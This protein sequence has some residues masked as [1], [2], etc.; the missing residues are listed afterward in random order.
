MKTKPFDMSAAKAGN[1]VV[2]NKSGAIFHPLD[3]EFS[4]GDG[5]LAIVGK[6]KVPMYTS[7]QIITVKHSDTAKDLSMVVETQTMWVNTYEARPQPDDYYP[8]LVQQSYKTKERALSQANNIVLPHH[9]L[10][11]VAVPVEVEL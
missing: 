8:S 4:F 5:G 10:K 2:H 1:L 7:H 11:S 3:F 6:I 9:L